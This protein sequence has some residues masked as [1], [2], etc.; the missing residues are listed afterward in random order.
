[1]RLIA[2]REKRQLFR[3][4]LADRFQPARCD[5][6]G[7]IPADF[8]KLARSA[9]ADALHRCLEARWRVVLHDASRPFGAEDAL[10]HG[11]IAVALDI[12]DLEIAKR[13][14]FHVD[15]NAAAAGTHVTGGFADLVRDFG[16]QVQRGLLW[17]IVSP[18]GSFAACRWSRRS[19]V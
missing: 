14:L 13:V 7:L 8:F 10:V 19:C 12:G 11:M 18:G 15:V 4:R 3:V 2:A 16:A 9:F 1:M 5:L 6:I 17:V